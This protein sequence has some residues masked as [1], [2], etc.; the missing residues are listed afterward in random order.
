ME[1]T[2]ISDK[3]SVLSFSESRGEFAWRLSIDPIIVVMGV[4]NSCDK[5]L[6]KVL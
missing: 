1:A 4:R 6:N 3:R 5:E 2:E